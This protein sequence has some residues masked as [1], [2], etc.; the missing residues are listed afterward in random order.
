MSIQESGEVPI[1][2]HPTNEVVPEMVPVVPFV[3]A[4]DAVHLEPHLPE[5]IVPMKPG[6][7][8]VVPYPSPPVY[9]P[10]KAW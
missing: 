7:S 8:T 3:P 9:P 1:P 4:P 2:V 10:A 6:L 5:T